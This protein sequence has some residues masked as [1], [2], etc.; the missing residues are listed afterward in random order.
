[1]VLVRGV[2]RNGPSNGWS[3]QI[4]QSNQSNNQV[5]A[6]TPTHLLL[7]ILPANLERDG[8]HILEHPANF[9]GGALQQ[10][11]RHL[12]VAAVLGDVG[13]VRRLVLQKRGE[14]R[15][16]LHSSQPHTRTQ[17]IYPQTS[18]RGVY[19]GKRRVVSFPLAFMPVHSEGCRS[20]LAAP[21]TTSSRSTSSGASDRRGRPPGSLM[22][23]RHLGRA[24]RWSLRPCLPWALCNSGRSDAWIEPI[25]IHGLSSI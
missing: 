18:S 24:R 8:L 1:M 17:H 9:G 25:R 11:P 23:A 5:K 13:G 6:T 2:E 22:A 3:A 12:C 19:W 10:V 7:Q 4:D 21:V 14:W 20:P 15:A 16:P